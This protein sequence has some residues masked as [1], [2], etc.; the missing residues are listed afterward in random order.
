MIK[1]KISE[2]Q[3]ILDC[4][5]KEFE[6]IGSPLHWDTF[7][8]LCEWAKQNKNWYSD[9]KFNSPEQFKDWKNYFMKHFYDCKPKYLYNKRRLEE[10]FAWFNVEYGFC[11]NYEL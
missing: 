10:E 5:N 11:A 8:E 3:F 7:P 2:D 4:I 6:I 9:Y 1:Q